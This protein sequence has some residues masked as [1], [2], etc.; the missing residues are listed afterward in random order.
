MSLY[1]AA[2]FV[3]QGQREEARTAVA[4]VMQVTSSASL[5]VLKPTTSYTNPATL[6]GFLAALREV[7]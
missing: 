7:G 6:E 4:E 5:E 2:R 3:E 1:L